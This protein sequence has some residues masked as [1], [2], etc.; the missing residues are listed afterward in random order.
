MHR[1]SLASLAAVAVVASVAP[2]VASI[3]EPTSRTSR[4]GGVGELSPRERRGKG[5]GRASRP[6]QA[7]LRRGAR[8]RGSK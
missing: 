7:K 8:R 3:P 4:P 5:K 1:R 6:S 2:P